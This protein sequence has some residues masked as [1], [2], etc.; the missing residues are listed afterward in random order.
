MRNLYDL[1]PEI[2]KMWSTVDDIDSVI[3]AMFDRQEAMSEDEMHNAL[4]SVRTLLQ[5]RSEK[6]F[7]VYSELLKEGTGK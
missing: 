5:I 4:I 2:M 3:W 7:N 1:E 6:L